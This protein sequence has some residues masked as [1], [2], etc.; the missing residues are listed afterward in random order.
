MCHFERF[1]HNIFFLKFLQK[2]FIRKMTVIRILFTKSRDPEFNEK[3]RSLQRRLG[4]VRIY[5][6]TILPLRLIVF[7]I[8]TV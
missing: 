7:L 1:E 3:I 4:R 6:A 8:S 2:V 5:K